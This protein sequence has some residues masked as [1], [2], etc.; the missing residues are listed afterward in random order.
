MFLLDA[1]TRN[2]QFQLAM[3]IKQEILWFPRALNQAYQTENPL[4]ST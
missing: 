1:K 2:R 4:R 3:L